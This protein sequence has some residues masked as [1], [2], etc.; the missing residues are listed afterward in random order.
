MTHR[1]I[2]KSRKAQSEA[3]I[4]WGT[5]KAVAAFIP[6]TY[7][8]LP[9]D[10]IQLSL[11]KRLEKYGLVTTALVDKVVMVDLTPKGWVWV[12]KHEMA[13]QQLQQTVAA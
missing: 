8:V 4:L 11:I 10:L 2:L 5:L 9:Q 12:G 1:T 3:R 13:R 7:G 6:G